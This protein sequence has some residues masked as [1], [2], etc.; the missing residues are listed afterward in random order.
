MIKS[1]LNILMAERGIRSIAELE[2]QLI[3]SNLSVSRPV[4]HKIYYNNN[5]NKTYIETILKLLDFFNCSIE[6]LIT[7]TSPKKWLL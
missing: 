2:R 1:R 6:E 7:Y 5:T 4:L 3:I